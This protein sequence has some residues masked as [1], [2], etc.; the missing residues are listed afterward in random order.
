MEEEI[1]EFKS[2]G[3]DDILIKPFDTQTL[4]LALGLTE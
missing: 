4:F 1:S 2:A 3:V